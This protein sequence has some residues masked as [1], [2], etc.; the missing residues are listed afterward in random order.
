MAIKILLIGFYTQ[1]YFN[2]NNKAIYKKI[3]ILE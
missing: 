2:S 3:H 1:D